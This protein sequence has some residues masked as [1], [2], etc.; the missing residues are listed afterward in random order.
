M[1]KGLKDG[2]KGII[3][4][5]LRVITGAHCSAC[6]PGSVVRAVGGCLGIL[7]KVTR[8]AL[9]PGGVWL[10]LG[11]RGIRLQCL[12]HPHSSSRMSRAAL[13]ACWQSDSY[14]LQG[15]DVI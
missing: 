8:F 10:P 12:L 14:H 2:V 13:Q 15:R 7:V 9:W 3:A 5:Y 4:A 6:L 11:P 1:T